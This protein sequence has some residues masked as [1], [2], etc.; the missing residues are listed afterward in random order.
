MPGDCQIRDLSIMNGRISHSTKKLQWSVDTYLGEGSRA[1]WARNNRLRKLGVDI[2]WHRKR[3]K[4][5]RFERDIIAVRREVPQT[6]HVEAHVRIWN[7][8]HGMMKVHREKSEQNVKQAYISPA[9][10]S[11]RTVW[12]SLVFFHPWLSSACGACVRW[13]P[14]RRSPNYLWTDDFRWIA[15]PPPEIRTAM[16][17]G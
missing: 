7:G 15:I 16:A 9:F 14:A 8:R 1:A 10:Y 12:S 4:L 17:D 6:F 3:N 13:F 2:R 5:V 11:L